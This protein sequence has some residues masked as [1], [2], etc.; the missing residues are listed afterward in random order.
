MRNVG[1]V[2]PSITCQSPR[3]GRLGPHLVADKADGQQLGEDGALGAEDRTESL[4]GDVSSSA[5]FVASPG[6]MA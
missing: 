6:Q 3:S 4:D 2:S 1:P 5:L